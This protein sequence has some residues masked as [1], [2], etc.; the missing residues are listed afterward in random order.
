M[1]NLRSS[2]EIIIKFLSDNTPEEKL[3]KTDAIFVFGNTNSVVAHHAAKLYKMGKAEKVI[4]SGK[5]RKIIPGF[6]TEAD[7]YAS[8]L[9]EKRVPLASLIL[10]RNAMNTVEN[11]IF[12]MRTC[13]EQLFYPRSLINVAMSPL[14]RRSRATFE[15]QFPDI[16]IHSSAPEISFS[17]YP[18]NIE[19]ILAEFDRFKEYSKKGD[20]APV[21]VPENV[22][23]AI[24]NL[25][26]K[27]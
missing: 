8:I 6:E 17:E 25:S 5:G 19:R 21:E 27:N 10:E 1:N 13:K 11:V 18:E 16:K 2:K 15:K 9:I 24:R 7:F 22:N 14:L 23:I 20:I 12:G 4:I 26:S 3:P